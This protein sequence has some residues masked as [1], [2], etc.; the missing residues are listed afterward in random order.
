MSREEDEI[1]QLI[2]DA[3]QAQFD[4]PALMALH[5][6]DAVVVNMAGRRVFGRP[7]FE[8]AM[9]QALASALQHVPTVMQVDRVQFLGP[10]CALVFCTKTVHDHRPAA[11]RT[12]LP[13]RAGMTTYV[14]VRRRDGWRIACAQTTPLAG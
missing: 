12:E 4:V 3:Q 14:V 8:A 5:D 6:E 2:A 9:T 1:R 10:E 11:D 13:G 7:A